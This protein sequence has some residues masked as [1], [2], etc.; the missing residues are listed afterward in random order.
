MSVTAQL[1]G[2]PAH[3]LVSECMIL[4]CAGAGGLLS[5]HAAA[6]VFR[7]QARPEE[8]IRADPARLDDPLWIH[9]NLRRLR[10]VEFSLAPGS[11]AS[12]GVPAY[13]QVTSPLR[14]YADLVMQRQLLSLAST[15]IP[16]VGAAELGEVVAQLETTVAAIQRAQNDAARYWT[17]V[18][19]RD[20]P[21]EELNA[22]VLEEQGRSLLLD[23]VDWGIRAK[24]HPAVPHRVGD[25][26]RV[27]LVRADP[28]E[29][30]IVVRD[31]PREG[32]GG[33]EGEP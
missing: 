28:R 2:S 29:D 4:A 19:L 23:L 25:R 3:V 13:T 10:K 9:E 22:L 33:K 12:L 32:P 24:L 15:G 5:E 30:R 20:R 1:P 18:A 6:G 11:H 21:G 17:L 26:I 8:E 16:A 7:V 27:L 14:R 31:G